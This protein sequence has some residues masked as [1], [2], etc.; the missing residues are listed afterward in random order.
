MATLKPGSVQGL[1]GNPEG[2]LQPFERV[3]L[4]GGD[5]PLQE[6]RSIEVEVEGQQGI[7]HALYGE[8]GPV[9]LDGGG[10]TRG[11][12]DPPDLQ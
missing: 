4:A 12:E 8:G 3:V 7:R 11:V 1:Q 5:G 6:R 10:G 9:G 2:L